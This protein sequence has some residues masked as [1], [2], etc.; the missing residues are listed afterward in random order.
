VPAFAGC[1][2]VIIPSM[3]DA[4]QL[5]WR[6]DFTNEEVNRL[7]ADAFEHRPLDDD[8]RAVTDRHSLGWVTARQHGELVGFVNLIGDGTVHAWIQDLIVA[9]RARRQGIGV[10]LLRV[11]TEEARAAGCEWLHV[12]FDDHL[13]AF[14]I[15]AAGFTPSNAGLIDLTTID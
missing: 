7:H 12:D 15:E 1:P 6:G 9:S 10:G 11:A 4:V 5:Q 8:W 2:L 14:Y 13:R 3:G